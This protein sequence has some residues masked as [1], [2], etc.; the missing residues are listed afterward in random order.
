[1]LIGD[2]IVEEISAGTLPVQ[3]VGNC[4]PEPAGVLVAKAASRDQEGDGDRDGQDD[5]KG[6]GESLNDDLARELG[7]DVGQVRGDDLYEEDVE[8]GCPVRPDFDVFLQ[9]L[10]SGDVRQDVGTSVGQ[11]V[12]DLRDV[13]RV[14]VEGGRELAEQRSHL[15]GVEVEEE[16]GAAEE[17][18]DL[19]EGDECVGE[20]A[21]LLLPLFD[22]AELADESPRGSPVDEVLP[23]SGGYQKDGHRYSPVERRGSI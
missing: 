19:P 23:P 9:Q 7:E 10:S 21:V 17:E 3:I 13:D 20:V 2:E 8:G 18:D 22:P 14:A 1:M 6:E 4:I 15:G 16:E 11:A 12:V 5:G